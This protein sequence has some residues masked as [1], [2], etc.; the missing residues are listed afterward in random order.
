M[1]VPGSP[2]LRSSRSVALGPLH[3]SCVLWEQPGSSSPLPSLSLPC[4]GLCVLPL[5]L[6]PW[7]NYFECL[8][9]FFSGGKLGSASQKPRSLRVSSRSCPLQ[10]AGVD[11]SP[12]AE[13]CQLGD[14]G[15]DLESYPYFL[16][17]WALKSSVFPLIRLFLCSFI[18]SQAAC[19][20]V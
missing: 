11:F 3:Q 6:F 5:S 1:E 19:G 4:R 13:S 16:L 14:G 18:C 20:A 12:C 9:C 10:D 17:S 15:W 7:G 8:S 2:C